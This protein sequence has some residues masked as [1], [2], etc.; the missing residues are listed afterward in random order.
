VWDIAW[1]RRRRS[2]AVDL[3]VDVV[4]TADRR[5]VLAVD[6]LL[7]VVEEPV[8][9]GLPWRVPRLLRETAETLR[10]RFSHSRT[11]ALA[12]EIAACEAAA[13]GLAVEPRPFPIRADGRIIA[14]ADIAVRELRH[15]AEIDGPHHELRPQQARDR[16]RDGRLGN[17]V[18][19]SVSR[20]PVVQV[21]DSPRDFGTRFRRDLQTL[22][23]CRSS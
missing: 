21:D 17:L 18:D 8:L 7:A 23:D 3:L 5:R 11:E 14:E 6:E 20:Y 4:T 10:P 22:I 12:R 1:T 2:G 15:D 16:R 9:Y 13:L 19:W